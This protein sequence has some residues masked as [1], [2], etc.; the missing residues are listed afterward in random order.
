MTSLECT[1][2]ISEFRCVS[3]I[4]VQENL[5]PFFFLFFFLPDLVVWLQMAKSEFFM[6][7]LLESGQ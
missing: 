7:I 6:E 2:Y 4:R 3:N 1:S 5:V